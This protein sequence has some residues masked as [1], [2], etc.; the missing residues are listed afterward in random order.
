MGAATTATDAADLGLMAAAGE[1][2]ARHVSARELLAA[3]AA[4]YVRARQDRAALVDVWERWMAE[5]GVDLL[6]EATI[7]APAPPRTIGYAPELR[8]P[9]P[10]ILLTFPWNVTGFPVAAL[11]AGVGTRSGLPVG[12]S[13]IGARGAEVDVV[14]AGIDLQEHALAPY[15]P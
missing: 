1:L 10:H 13:L 11:P 4:A 8:T 3:A 2:R 7:P 14:Q 6:L 9:D 5:N 12:V 15:G